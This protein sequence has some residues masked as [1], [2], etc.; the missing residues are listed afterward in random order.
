MATVEPLPSQAASGAAV[1]GADLLAWRSYLLALGGRP[2]A[3][4]WLLDLGGGLRWRDLQ[5]LRLDPER[6]VLLERPLA[7]LEA[8]WQRHRRD[9]EPLQY[10]VGLCPWRDLELQVAPGVLIPRQETEL[11][12][13]L[14]VAL[15]PSD[16][17]GEASALHWADLGTG[18]GCLAVA[19]ARAFPGRRGWA[20]DASDEALRQA[21]LNLAAAAVLPAVTLRQGDWWQPLRP[22]WGKLVLVVSNP[23]YIPSATVQQLEP[24]VRRHEP[25][26][27]LDGGVDGLDSIRRI[28]AEASQALAPGGLL[29]L[30]H[31]HDQSAAVGQLLRAAGLTDLQVHRDLEGVPRFAS[32]RRPPLA[33][34][35]R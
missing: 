23:P 20:V 28:A 27:A 12:V 9:A 13:D 25:L 15:M 8:L 21:R 18:S 33:E 16:G 2:D 30:E 31:H 22:C 24:V 4:D 19:L 6:T 14:A 34:E 10:L 5:A 35:S 1:H 26:A 3:F 17:F 32:A 11:L 7:E 29:L